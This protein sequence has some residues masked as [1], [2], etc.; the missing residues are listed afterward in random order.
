MLREA[1][2][3]DDQLRRPS[4]QHKARE[5]LDNVGIRLDGCFELGQARA[6]AVVRDGVVRGGRCPSVDRGVAALHE[7][8]NG[9]ANISSC[10]RIPVGRAYRQA[11]LRL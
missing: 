10:P 1:Q 5:V 7:P 6:Q 4:L 8:L 11:L 9:K 2:T 3:L